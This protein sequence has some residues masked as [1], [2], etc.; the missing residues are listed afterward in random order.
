[1]AAGNAVLYLDSPENNETAGD[2]GIRY[3]KSADDLAAKL[4]SVL[5]DPMAREQLAVRAKERAHNL[6]RWD[7]VAAKYEALFMELLQ[8]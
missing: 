7:S 3:G 2:A 1:M 5:D 6:Y 8:R 4:Q